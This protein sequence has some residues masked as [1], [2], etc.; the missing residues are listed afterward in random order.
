M[1]RKEIVQKSITNFVVTLKKILL[2]L[3]NL[4]VDKLEDWFHKITHRKVAEVTI[5]SR[6]PLGKARLVRPEELDKSDDN[7]KPII[8]TGKTT[9]SV[10]PSQPYGELSEDEKH[11]DI[12]EKQIDGKTVKYATAEPAVEEALPELD[13]SKLDVNKTTDELNQ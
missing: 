7:N 1:I 11:L 6:P 10:T 12:K 2:F 4:V 13:L 5:I 9:N 8:L 3:S